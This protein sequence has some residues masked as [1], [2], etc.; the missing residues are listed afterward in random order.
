MTGLDSRAGD[1]IRTHDVQLGKIHV[2][3]PAISANT[4][5]NRTCGSY[6]SRM[7]IASRCE[8]L[9][10]NAKVATVAGNLL[11][12]LPGYFPR[13]RQEFRRQGWAFLGIRGRKKKTGR[14]CSPRPG[15]EGSLSSRRLDRRASD[16]GGCR[17]G[18]PGLAHGAPDSEFARLPPVD[19]CGV[20]SPEAPVHLRSLPALQT[21]DL[22]FCTRL[23]DAGI[24]RLQEAMTG[25]R[26]YR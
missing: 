12:T 2:G 18:A 24:G 4:F 16:F 23:T 5:P 20:G 15:G 3:P 25:C 22:S 1:A 17:I 11:G 21:L 7:T 9:P 26:I 19:G 14:S 10:E 6:Q 13:T 8:K